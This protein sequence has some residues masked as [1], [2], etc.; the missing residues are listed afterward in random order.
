MDV[1]C[2][3][4]SSNPTSASLAGSISV[5]TGVA[6]SVVDPYPPSK[7]SIPSV[8]VNPTPTVSSFRSNK[9]NPEGVRRFNNDSPKCNGDESWLKLEVSSSTS[10]NNFSRSFPNEWL[11]LR[12][13]LTWSAED[14]D[15]LFPNRRAF[16]A[17]AAARRASRASKLGNRTERGPEIMGE[18]PRVCHGELELELFTFGRHA[19][20]KVLEP[21]PSE[22]GVVRRVVR[23][24]NG[25]PRLPSSSLELAP[26]IAIGGEDDC[27]PSSPPF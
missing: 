4:V 14:V 22:E 10:F 25:L 21:V 13:N 9:L 12:L 8:A 6:P 5:R 15:S 1:G 24:S 11:R 19:A 17:A 7:V 18:Y 26:G 3:A 16:A 20:K 2:V 23:P 27:E